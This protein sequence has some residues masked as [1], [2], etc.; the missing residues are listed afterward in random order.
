MAPSSDCRDLVQQVEKCRSVTSEGQMPSLNSEGR[1]LLAAFCQILLLWPSLGTFLWGLTSESSSETLWASSDS[2][3]CLTGSN[4]VC[5]MPVVA[6]V[7][8]VDWRWQRLRRRGSVPSQK[9][10]TF[11]RLMDM[12]VREVAEGIP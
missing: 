1:S 5:E 10:T 3:T 12:R 7:A 6:P 2:E 4:D 11:H 8:P 9:A